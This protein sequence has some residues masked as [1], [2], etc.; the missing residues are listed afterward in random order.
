MSTD[1]FAAFARDLVRV[2]SGLDARANAVAEKVGQ[3]ALRTAKA[4][5]P[6]ESGTMRRNVRLVRKGSTSVVESSTFYAA[7]QEY[8]TSRMAPNPFMSPAVETWGPRLVREV[9]ALRDD[10]VGEL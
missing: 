8:G 2:A 7:F 6:V 1:G 5:A 3:G 9:E 4:N 10:V